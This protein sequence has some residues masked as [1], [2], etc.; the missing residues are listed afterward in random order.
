[1]LDE[2]LADYHSQNADRDNVILEIRYSEAIAQ[3]ESMRPGSVTQIES[4]VEALLAEKNQERLSL[5]KP[6]MADYYRIFA[7]L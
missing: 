1:M 6:P 4:A 3:L 2:G 5:S 7:L